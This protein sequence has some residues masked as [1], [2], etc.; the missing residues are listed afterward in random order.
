MLYNNFDKVIYNFHELLG[1]GLGIARPE[2]LLGN[3]NASNINM[4]ILQ[5]S[6][7]NYYQTMFNSKTEMSYHI[8]G[9]GQSNEE[10]ITRVLGEPIERYSFMSFYW[11]IK[12]QIKK[13][14]WDKLHAGKKAEVLPFELIN[15]VD[16]KNKFFHHLN[17]SDEVTWVKLKNLCKNNDVYYPLQ[18]LC[19]EDGSE[20]L[21]YPSM[22]TGTATHV[23][24][25]NALINAMTEQLQIHLFLTAWYGLRK[26]PVLNWEKS[27]SSSLDKIFKDTFDF[28]KVSITV[29]DCSLK[30][31]GFYNYIAFVKNKENKAPYCAFGLQGGFNAEQVLL[32]AVME[33]TAIYVNLQGFYIFKEESVSKLDIKTVL[34]QYN[35]DAPFLYWSNANDLADKEKILDSLSDTVHKTVF[36]SNPYVTEKEQ[37]HRLMNYYKNTLNYFSVLDITAPEVYKYGYRTVRCIAPEFVSMNLPAVTYKNHPY[38]INNGGIKNGNFPHPLP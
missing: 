31:I 16:E 26:L 23:N 38:F 20:K 22:S 9:Y 19:N 6:I 17:K 18:I 35:L 21:Y 14:S 5:L 8:S 4:S 25:E 2:L 30:E 37:L 33:A 27:L 28:S 1:S 32:R 10:A 29:L 12:N 11:L 15:I 13:N 7:P 3:R 34:S 24:Y 36:E